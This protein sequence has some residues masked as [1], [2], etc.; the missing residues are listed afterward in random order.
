M[1]SGRRDMALTVS[2]S[3]LASLAVALTLIPMLAALAVGS[4]D[5]S[6]N[7]KPAPFWANYRRWPRTA[8]SIDQA[9]ALRMESADL[10]ATDNA[11]LM[12]AAAFS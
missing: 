2:F 8:D 9:F 1:R 12:L 7:G 6:G 3:L 5:G 4:G 11:V 10:R